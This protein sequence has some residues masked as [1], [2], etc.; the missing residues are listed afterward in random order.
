MTW[1]PQR[2]GFTIACVSSRLIKRPAAAA[3]TKGVH[4]KLIGVLPS[5]H[6]PVHNCSVVLS[7][8]FSTFVNLVCGIIHRT[9]GVDPWHRAGHDVRIN[10]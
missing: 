10:P 3:T 9:C 1:G 2:R 8:T 5:S 4:R 6:V 7:M